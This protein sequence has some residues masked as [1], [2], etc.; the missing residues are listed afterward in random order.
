MAQV[1]QEHSVDEDNKRFVP[2][3]VWETAEETE[4]VL[5]FLISQYKTAGGPLVYPVI[6]KAT[7]DNIGYVCKT[8]NILPVL[9]TTVRLTAADLSEWSA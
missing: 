5:K 9:N 4:E 7:K 6:V 3:E 1:V 2:D 8:K